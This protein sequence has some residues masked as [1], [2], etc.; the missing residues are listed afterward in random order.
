MDF[1][2]KFQVSFILSSKAHSRIRS[3]LGLVLELNQWLAAL[4]EI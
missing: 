1:L 4:E 3:C 2:A